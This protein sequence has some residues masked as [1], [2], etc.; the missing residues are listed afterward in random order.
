MHSNLKTLTF[1]NM[2]FLSESFERNL[3][4]ASESVAYACCKL[5]GV[6]G[7]NS[8]APDSSV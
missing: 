1:S 3:F 5:T 4:I 2:E 7:V 8:A 6:I